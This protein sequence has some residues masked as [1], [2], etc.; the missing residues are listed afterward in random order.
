MSDALSIKFYEDAALTTP[1]ERLHL[2]GVEG[3]F[4]DSNKVI[5]LGSPDSDRKWVDANG[6][7]AIYLYGEFDWD[8]W[9][10]AN[11]GAIYGPPSLSSA[12]ILFCLAEDYAP[13]DEDLFSGQLPLPG[14][15]QGGVGNA[16]AINVAL[17]SWTHGSLDYFR[18]YTDLL[19]EL[20]A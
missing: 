7:S 19:E 10:R 4:A 11:P 15:I 9:N 20:N 3:R 6:N 13:G 17:R 8:G 12:E 1:L 16:I 5:Y 18:I 14:M 2:S